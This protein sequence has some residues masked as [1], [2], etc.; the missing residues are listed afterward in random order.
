M[1][2][3]LSVGEHSRSVTHHTAQAN[4]FKCRSVEWKRVKTWIYSRLTDRSEVGEVEDVRCSTPSYTSPGLG[5]GNGAGLT[6]YDSMFVV[7]VFVV[8]VFVVTVFVVTMFVVTVFVV[9]TFVITSSL[10]QLPSPRLG[11]VRVGLTFKKCFLPDAQPW[12]GLGLG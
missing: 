6:W 1:M 9:T 8:T 12:R 10:F 2:C 3:L 5:G 7:T 4:V 11:R